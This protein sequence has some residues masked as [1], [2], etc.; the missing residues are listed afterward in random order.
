MQLTCSVHLTKYINKMRINQASEA[1]FGI[2]Q[3]QKKI[4]ADFLEKSKLP[5]QSST[6]HV[7]KS[8]K[9]KIH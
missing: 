1:E 7:F 4:F 2:W 3:S 8:N 9:H 5:S 6:N